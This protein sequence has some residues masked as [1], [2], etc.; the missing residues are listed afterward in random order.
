MTK[1]K[2]CGMM[3]PEDL[4]AAEG[5]D[6]LGFVVESDSF[7]SLPLPK[8][9]SLMSSC[10]C[11]RVA[12]TSCDDTKTILSLAET[13]EPDVI[14]VHSLLSPSELSFLAEEC[15]YDIWGLVPIGTGEE[16]KRARD[17]SDLLD[18]VVLDTH[19]GRAG[20]S[21]KRHD[22]EVSRSIREALPSSPVVLAGGL[23]PDNVAEAIRSV[24]PYAVDVSSGVEKSRRKDP[25]LIGQFMRNAREEAP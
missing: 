20:G 2:I 6:Y 1:V 11:K 7:R 16:M 13:L 15:P 10:S 14:Q 24:R 18:A 3:R 17:I 25:C 21:G 4:E 19:D 23:S 12:V 9:K 5:A 22:W 8:A